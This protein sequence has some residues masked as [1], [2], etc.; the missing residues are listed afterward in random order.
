M[1]KFILRNNRPFLQLNTNYEDIMEGIPFEKELGEATYKELSMLIDEGFLMQGLRAKALTGVKLAGFQEKSAIFDVKS[2][3][4]HNN[5]ITYTNVFRFKE[6]DMFIDEE[7]MKP[8]ERAKMLFYHGNLELHCTC[9]S[10]LFH[11]YQYLLT[12]LDSAVMPEERPPNKTNPRQRG[13]VCK[14]LNRSLK[15]FPFWATSLAK[16]IKTNHKV[17]EG[18]D[19]VTDRKT[20]LLEKA[21]RDPKFEITYKDIL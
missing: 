1:S 13:I 19:D 14:H 8:I 16:Y 9:P 4:H 15:A 10:F 18:L 21:L 11:G 17:E 5:N 7:T 12:V 2:S 20:D 6:W 3:E